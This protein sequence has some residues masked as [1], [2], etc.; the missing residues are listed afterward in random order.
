MIG[1]GTFLNPVLKIATVVAILAAV[2]I[3]IVKPVLETSESASDSARE[4]G[5]RIS[6]QAE[7]HSRR[8]QL[9][10][11]RGIALDAARSARIAGDRERARRI[12]E[13]V[14]RA[15]DDPVEMDFCRAL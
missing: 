2:S 4:Q 8:V 14:K 5:E 3:F 9:N 11:A 12:V 13:C 10:V 7:E 6:R 1:A 15:G